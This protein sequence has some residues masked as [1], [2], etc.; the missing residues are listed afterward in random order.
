MTLTAALRGGAQQQILR[1]P[2]APVPPPAPAHALAVDV[3]NYTGPLS[4][5]ALEA[6]K[7]RGIGLVIVQAVDPPAPY[8]PTQTVG[9]IRACVAAGLQ[10]EA[11]VYLWF[12]LGASDIKR[13]LELLKGLPISRV[14]LDVEDTTA[15]HMSAKQRANLV[16]AAL[17][18]IQ[19]AGFE[20]GIYTGGW[21]WR[22]EQYMANTI[23]F[24][25][26][27]LWSAQY[28][29]IA[30]ASVFTPYGGWD[31]CTLKQFRGTTTLDGVPNVDL[32][33]SA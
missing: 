12:T 23:A 18:V 3:S 33:V 22:A 19:A 32:D 7:R 10:V 20:T 17:D 8:P 2:A 31:R 16:M 13:K 11:Y 25:A 28:D 26:F 1:A 21:F 24:R 15:T 4:A 9:Q 5:A 14:W 6:W 27:N 29:G 30:D